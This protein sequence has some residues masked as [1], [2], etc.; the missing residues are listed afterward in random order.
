MPTK[1]DIE[2]EQ[3][4]NDY[5]F[6]KE[7]AIYRLQNGHRLFV[8]KENGRIV[9]FL[10]AE[11]K[12]STISWFDLHMHIPQDMIYITGVYTIPEFRNRGIAYKLKR[13]I[14]H[15]LKKEGIKN[16]IEVV[17]PSNATALKMDK[18]IGFREYQIVYYKR[19]WFIRCFCVRKHRSNQ[20][21]TFI[22]VF[23]TPEIIW[24]AFL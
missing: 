17:D 16:L 8:L 13:E 19:Y 22:S 9:F 5:W 7:D 20:Q 14:F 23:K 2:K 10:W 15:Y 6:R 21:R 3:K 24:K 1:E 11:K 12:Q 18:K 4:Y